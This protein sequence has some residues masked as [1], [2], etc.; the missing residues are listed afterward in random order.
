MPERGPAISRRDLFRAVGAGILVSFSGGESARA[1]VLG[2]DENEPELEWVAQ[3]RR[4][5][6]EYDANFAYRHEE[7]DNWS[8]PVPGSDGK[9]NGDCDDYMIGF[10]NKIV[11]APGFEGVITRWD[12][13]EKTWLGTRRFKMPLSLDNSAHAA[14]VVYHPPLEQWALIDNG[15]LGRLVGPY[16]ERERL[17]SAVVDSY[18]ESVDILSIHYERQVSQVRALRLLKAELPGMGA[19]PDYNLNGLT[20]V[21]LSPEPD[22]GGAYLHQIFDQHAK[23]IYSH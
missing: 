5:Q 1:S 20:A 14:L 4:I 19:Q 17:I 2:K 7:V 11:N 9:F 22:G 18:A 3:L 12:F 15:C 13:Q 6:A 23:V 21:N 8:T 16:S 10:W